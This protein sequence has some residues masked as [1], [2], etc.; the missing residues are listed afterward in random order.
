MVIPNKRD[1]AKSVV[2][3]QGLKS[4]RI[5]LGEEDD[6]GNKLISPCKCAGTTKYIHKECLQE[7]LNSKRVTRELKYSII[8]V[9]KVSQCELCKNNFPGIT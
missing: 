6:E 4:C 5:C 1:K 9:F 7:W 8:Y 3:P 2:I